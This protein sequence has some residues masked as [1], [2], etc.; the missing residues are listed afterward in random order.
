[1]MSDPIPEIFFEEYSNALSFLRERG[2][3]LQTL[4]EGLVKELIF[5]KNFISIRLVLDVRDSFVEEFFVIRLAD[6]EELGVSAGDLLTQ[7][8]SE[9]PDL[10]GLQEEVYR[11]WQDKKFVRRLIFQRDTEAARLLFR[12]SAQ[13]LAIA[14]QR[15]ETEMLERVR[16]RFGVR[17]GD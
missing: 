14:I 7:N 17:Q 5:S 9:D 12:K 3:L 2:Y 4:D 16:V 10:K 8:E 15:Y 13:W 6:G 11:L 1:M